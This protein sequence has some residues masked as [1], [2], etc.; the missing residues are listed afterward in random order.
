ML[1]KLCLLLSVFFII[2]TL[3]AQVTTSSITGRVSSASNEELVGATITATHQPT[4]TVYRTQTRKG[5]LYDIGNMNPGGPYSIEVSFVNY[6]KETRNDVYL[7]LGENQRL[8]IALTQSNQVL[9]GVVVSTVRAPGA[10]SRGG[11]ETNIGRDKIQNLPSVGRNLQDYLRFTPQ[12]KFSGSNGNVVG[13]SIAGQNN[14]FNSFTVD[15]AVNNDVFGLSATGTNG[16]QAGV[17]PISIDAIDQF[18][19]LVS[20]YDASIGNFTGGG[21]NATTRSGTNKIQAS[22]YYFYQNEDLAGK[23]PTGPKEQAT[24]FGDFSAKTYGFRVGG[25]IIKSKLFYF[26]N[27]EQIKNTRPQPFDF[28]NYRGNLKQTDIDQLATY[29]RNTYQY[30]PGGYLDNPEQVESQRIASKLDWNIDSKN[31]FSL[32]YRYNKAE[33]FNTVGSNATTVNFFN[34][35]EYFPSVT[36]S[37]SAE[38]R[39]NFS[40]GKSNRL[41]I[42]YTGVVDDRGAIGNP[43][44]RVT[45]NDGSSANQIRFGTEE[46]S[47][48]NL[49]EQRNIGILDFFRFNRGK[50]SFMVGTDNEFSKSYN[51][52]IRQNYGSYTYNSLA[53]FYNAATVRP[54]R[55]QR[56]FSRLDTKGEAETEAAAEFN[57]LRLGVF[58]NDEIKVSNNFTLN[59]GV[60]ADRTD[61]LTTPREDKFFNDT[62]IAKI[63]QYYDL[64]GARSGQISDPKISIS[65]RV[66]F[67]VKFPDENLT[68]RGGFGLFTGRVPLVWPGGVYNQN[69]VAIGGVD[70]N[71]TSTPPAPFFNPNPF[72]QPDAATLGISVENQRGQVDLIAKDF[73]LPKIFRTSLAVDRSF[74]KGWR[75]SIEAL[76]NKNINE[77]YYQNVNILPPTVQL[78]N[79]GGDTRSIYTTGNAPTRIPMRFNGVN[80][81]QGNIFLLSNNEGK[82]GYSYN[83]SIVLDK[84]FSNNFSLNAS[85]TYGNSVTVYEG[86]S[87]QNN[88][89]WNNMPA[90]SGRNFIV[91]STSDYDLG[92][93]VTA[94]AS[95]RFNYAKGLMA[96]TVT[97]L[98]TGQSGDPYS[99]VYGNSLIRDVSNTNARDL[100]YVP[101]SA[102][103][104]AMTFVSLTVGSGAS[105][106]TYSDVQ[107]KAALEQYIQRD[108]YL[109][110]RRGQ[111]AERN[112]SK[113]PFQSRFDLS[114]K[115]DFNLKIGKERYQ[116]QLTYDIFNFANLIDRD[117]GRTYFMSN[118]NNFSLISVNSF[119]GT[120]PRY[121]FNPT[122]LNQTP[123]VVNTSSV[124]S[125]SARWISQV[126]LR[127][128]LN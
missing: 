98:Y 46:F 112:E 42:T 36:N 48:A 105:A 21:I 54:I 102:D 60:R 66:G 93:R 81:Y 79:N 52:F 49:L 9:Q 126:G 84:T 40:G 101:T 11:V 125:F 120:T 92:S 15:G 123:W 50:H 85:Y 99:Y 41:L 20:P 17:G 27:A 18:N 89:Q 35:G 67:T 65:P 12:A 61:F 56:S 87:S 107:Q 103:I 43:F 37:L 116:L 16:G 28:A 73:R 97:L 57:T 76:V 2:Q 44:P 94:Y 77:I 5:G 53:D 106:V 10:S 128:N 78:T 127:L 23:T 6:G 22:A 33:R 30:D 24:R 109:N 80:P 38:L 25:A 47:T 95:K 124:P 122:Q 100:I 86:T 121:T 1:K 113:L 118:F 51:V 26:L 3:P 64:K 13:V 96:T 29:L 69:G 59:L 119:S 58:F 110:N 31:K 108:K 72:G 68:L 8:D 32:S 111:Y 82:K 19:V 7:A 39:S 117:R 104:A 55:Y 63:S 114:L 62:A 115:Q 4:G 83:V 14:R 91:R 90:I 74:G 34:N 71:N 88:S 45:I 70:L 75:T